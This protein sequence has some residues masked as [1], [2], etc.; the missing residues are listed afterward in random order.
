LVIEVTDRDEPAVII[1]SKNHFGALVNKLWELSRHTEK[2]DVPN[3]MGSITISG[4]LEAA[5][6]RAS[7]KFKQSIKKSAAKL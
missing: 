6:K 3:L 5:S 1:L 4:D 2:S 7:A